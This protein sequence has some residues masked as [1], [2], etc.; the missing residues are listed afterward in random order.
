MNLRMQLQSRQAGKTRQHETI[1]RAVD[2][3]E[4]ISAKLQAAGVSFNFERYYPYVENGEAV[5][6]PAT[7]TR[8]AFVQ[9]L[10]ENGFKC[11][12]STPCRE[13]YTKGC[14]IIRVYW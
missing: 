9:A 13:S 6:T 8:K 5:I 14:A 4:A 1:V 7:G 10:K 12:V 2:A 3:L 11:A